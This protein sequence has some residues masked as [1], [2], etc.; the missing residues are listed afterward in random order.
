VGCERLADETTSP[1]EWSAP[2]PFPLLM[3]QS[4]SLGLVLALITTGPYSEAQPVVRVDGNTGCEGCSL[5]LTKVTTVILNK[6]AG[7]AHPTHPAGAARDSRGRV[8][9]TFGHASPP[10]VFDRTG[11]LIGELKLGGRLARAYKVQVLP[12][13]TTL[14]LDMGGRLIYDPHLKLIRSLPSEELIATEVSLP[15]GRRVVWTGYDSSSSS[16]KVDIRD[17]NDS[18]RVSLGIPYIR[19]AGPNLPIFH[20][21]ASGH[22]AFWI[23]ENDT[24]RLERWRLD[25]QPQIIITRSASWWLSKAARD[26]IMLR[27]YKPHSMSLIN[28]PSSVDDLREDARGRIW[29]VI[30]VPSKTPQGLPLFESW[31]QPYYKNDSVIEVFDGTTGRLLVSERVHG[32]VG[33]FVSEGYFVKYTDTD[34]G[35]TPSFEIWKA[36]L[37]GVK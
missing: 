4:I 6:K 29:A 19:K 13:D 24:Y 5:R 35:R 25:G 10:R 27:D 36:E 15:S 21:A 2:T 22:D 14:I 23:A 37:I 17:R 28:D 9:A 18:T 3:H 1:F 30:R 8:I 32:F 33:Q 7:I 16:L 20:M 34:N 11:K 12:G 26:S 31:R